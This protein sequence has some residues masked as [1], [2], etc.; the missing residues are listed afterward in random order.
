MNEEEKKEIVDLIVERV[1]PEIREEI[2]TTVNGKIDKLQKKVDDMDDRLE[3]H[4]DDVGPFLQGWKGAKVIGNMLK[5]IAGL[6]IAIGGAIA[7]VSTI[8]W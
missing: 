3:H 4:M 8:K 7:V 6:V 1:A 2:G 5:W